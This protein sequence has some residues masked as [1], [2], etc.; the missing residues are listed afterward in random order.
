VT[1]FW[2]CIPEMSDS[3]EKEAHA[4]VASGFTLS[5]R[6]QAPSS[7]MDSWYQASLKH[8]LMA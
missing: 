5:G 3:R 8:S 4:S 1:I 2:C 7:H 6:R